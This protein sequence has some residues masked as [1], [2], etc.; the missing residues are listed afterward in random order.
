MVNNSFSAELFDVQR[1]V[2]QGGPLPPY[3]F[4]LVLEVLALSIRENKSFQGILV[5]GSEIKLGLFA[6]ELTVVL[7]NEES[8]NEF[9]DAIAN[10]GNAQ[11]LL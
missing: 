3:Q 1:G 7:R 10:F 9:F 8:L 4:V 2:S 11:D 6:Y 5:D